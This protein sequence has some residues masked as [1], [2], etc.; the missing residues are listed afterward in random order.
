MCS[1]WHRLSA[2]T[3]KSEQSVNPEDI[4]FRGFGETTV[5]WTV[6][7]HVGVY[8][9][10]RVLE[11]SILPTGGRGGDIY[12]YHY[13]PKLTSAGNNMSRLLV[14]QESSV[15]SYTNGNTMVQL[16]AGHG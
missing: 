16:L 14:F 6:F 12:L 1:L 10:G 2:E 11:A 4:W 8:L 5:P 9:T 13:K 15:L 3:A 7:V